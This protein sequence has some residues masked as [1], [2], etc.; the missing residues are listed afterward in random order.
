MS[1]SNSLEQYFGDILVEGRSRNVSPEV[2]REL[3]KT[4]ARR[5][6]RDRVPLNESIIKIAHDEQSLNPEHIKRIVEMANTDVYLHLHGNE[7]DKNV[8]FDVANPHTILEKLGSIE[9][10]AEYDLS[11]YRTSPSKA[12][13]IKLASLPWIDEELEQDTTT[14]LRHADPRNDLLDLNEKLHS[15]KDQLL[16]ERENTAYKMKTAYNKLYNAVKSELRDGQISED[17]DER[18]TFSN[19]AQVMSTVSN[20]ELGVLEPIAT[21]LMKE[22][23]AS[24]EQLNQNFKKVAGVL[25]NPENPIVKH[26]SEYVKLASYTRELTE[27]IS[28]A[29][30]NISQVE[31]LI[32]HAALN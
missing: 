9:K 14:Y 25:I 21:N 12:R 1:N 28:I 23:V 31:D 7:R 20:S 4:A 17:S 19:I 10:K 3:S 6:I 32:R 11:D 26:F 5:Y 22:K 2:L 15:A 16:S 24:F 18:P 8:Y 30:A 27:A 29:T 13:A